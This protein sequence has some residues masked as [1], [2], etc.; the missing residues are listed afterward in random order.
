M[1]NEGRKRDAAANAILG[2]AFAA[3]A[4]QSPESLL[5]SGKVEGPGFQLMSR[6]MKKRK[7]ADRNLDSPRVSEPAR[8]KRIKSEQKTFESFM[9]EVGQKCHDE[10]H[11]VK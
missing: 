3:N 11:E 8:N 5:K 1:I 10:M 9:T 4:A 2:V 7:E 6:M